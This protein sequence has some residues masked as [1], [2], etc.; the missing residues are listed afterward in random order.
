MTAER[1]RFFR[2]IR[3]RLSAWY[4]LILFILILML[5]AGVAQVL[6]RDL[7]RD[8]DRRIRSTAEQM[9]EQFEITVQFGGQNAYLQ[10]PPPDRFSFPSQLIQIVDLRGNVLFASQNLGGRQIPTI[11]ARTGQERSLRYGT[12]ELDGETV[13]VVT[14]PVRLQSGEIIGAI[15]VAEPLIQVDSMLQDLRRQ[16]FLA[17]AA[18]ALLAAVS[19]WFLAGRA[20]KP[21]DQM[22]QRAKQIAT[23]SID[24]PALDQRLDVPPTE[25]ELARLATTF[26]TVLGQMQV[27]FETQRQFVA[28]ASHELRTPLTAIRGNVELL[29]MQLARTGGLDDEVRRSLADLERESMRMSRLTD[30]LLTLARSEAPGGL[31]IQCR[32]FDLAD[33]ARS[34]VR[35][36]L[37]SGSDPS[38]TIEGDDEVPATGDRDRI[39]QVMLILCDNAR[40]YTPAD[41]SI[42]LRVERWGNGAR[43]SVTDTGVGIAPEDQARIFT[44]FYRA[45]VSRERS[46]GGTGLGLAIARAIVVAHGGSIDVQSRLGAGST[47]TV[48]LPAGQCVSPT[49]GE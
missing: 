21:V 10:S 49:G 34:A 26:N 37:A 19:G 12:V 38:V 7:R 25:D 16:F 13:R 40:R 41:G 23:S 5:G 31:S 8:V 14:Y 27:S 18:G 2:S 48:V 45:D 4:A 33:A 43:F 6:E 39:E 36:V 32:P 29:E 46:S 24:A 15:D 44:R 42:V 35:T 28:D 1:T 9:L 3:F 47:F 11:P 17:A 30:D 22:V 20:L